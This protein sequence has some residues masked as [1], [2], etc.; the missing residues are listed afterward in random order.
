MVDRESHVANRLV[1]E[2]GLDTGRSGEGDDELDD[3]GRR[4][5]GDVVDLG[6][7]FDGVDASIASIGCVDYY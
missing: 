7:E 3:L 5:H 1:D 6:S 2:L 4:D